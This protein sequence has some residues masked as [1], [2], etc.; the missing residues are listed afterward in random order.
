MLEGSKTSMKTVFNAVWMLVLWTGCGV[1]NSTS[2]VSKL[3]DAEAGS[4]QGYL[5]AQN[6][7]AAQEEEQ[8]RFQ[9]FAELLEKTSLSATQ[10]KDSRY[11]YFVAVDSAIKTFSLDRL[12]AMLESTE[13]DRDRVKLAELLKYHVVA[14]VLSTSDLC[15]E[16]K[17]VMTV[18]GSFLRFSDVKVLPDEVES[19][20]AKT[21]VTC[22]VNGAKILQANIAV[23]KSLVHV[24]DSFLVPT[25]EYVEAD[26]MLDPLL[27]TQVDAS[28]KPEGSA[29]REEA[30]LDQAT[31]TLAEDITD[32]SSTGN[33]A[34]DNS[35]NTTKNSTVEQASSP[36]D[37]N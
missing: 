36:K 7:Q 21:S 26:A 6:E 34:G 18:Q 16:D 30:V 27:D 12:K 35:K 33:N 17:T 28:Q 3:A 4:L 15:V 31:K 25:E 8:A 13:Q 37:E 20:Q 22:K 24:I 10:K 14:E 1:Q 19:T 11:T 32:D 29:S 5:T 2:N 9:I 23:G